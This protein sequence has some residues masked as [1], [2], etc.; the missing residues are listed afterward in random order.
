MA[1]SKRYTPIHSIT[2]AESEKEDKRLCN[3]R[4]RREHK[5]QI[6]DAIDYGINLGV[7][8]L[9]QQDEVLTKWEMAKDGKFWFDPDEQ[10]ELMR[11]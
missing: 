9:I 11:K 6:Q 5:K 2:S 3:T 7:N 1:N 8:E 4:V 10:P